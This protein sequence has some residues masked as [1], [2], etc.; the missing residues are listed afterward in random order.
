MSFVKLVLSSG[1][2]CLR[3]SVRVGQGVAQTKRLVSFAK[4]VLSGRDWCL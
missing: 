3:R 1:D 2:W 4:L